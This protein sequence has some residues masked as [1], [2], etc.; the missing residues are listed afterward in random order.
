MRE[1]IIGELEFTDGVR[2]T[3]YEDERGQYVES[4]GERVYGLWLLP[5]E[6]DGDL[7]LVVLA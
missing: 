4:D 7:P 2:R 5:D 6:Y 3:V 1:R